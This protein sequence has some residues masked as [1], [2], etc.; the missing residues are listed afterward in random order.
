L[1]SRFLVFVL[2]HSD[3]YNSNFHFFTLF[4]ADPYPDPEDD[5]IYMFLGLPDQ[6]PLVLGPDPA[7]DHSIIKQKY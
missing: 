7:P 3:L 5:R 6:D 4:V 2:N 1:V